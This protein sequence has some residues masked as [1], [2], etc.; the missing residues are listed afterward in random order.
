MAL[1]D[2]LKQSLV[3]SVQI[4]ILPELREKMLNEIKDRLRHLEPELWRLYIGD[5]P[6]AEFPNAAWS[7]T[8]EVVGEYMKVSDSV[9]REISD[10]LMD[11]SQDLWYEVSKE[12]RGKIDFIDKLIK[13]SNEEIEKYFNNCQ[14]VF[15]DT[16]AQLLTDLAFQYNIHSF[17]R[18]AKP[19]LIDYKRMINICGQAIEDIF[20][21]KI[22]CRPQTI[23]EIYRELS[24]YTSRTGSQE[25]ELFFN[26]ISY[27]KIII[28]KHFLERLNRVY[29]LRNKY[30]HGNDTPTDPENDFRDCVRA[31]LEEKYGILH[32]LYDCLAVKP[33]VI[34]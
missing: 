5:D 9:K 14:L 12:I 32:V 19:E 26:R 7:I 13:D 20:C 34:N 22:F 1:R 15:G 25:R 8:E 30:S 31:M 17:T 6:D 11:E 23:G 3:D 28:G 10:T 18:S 16:A 4:N 29:T 27:G 24:A 33:S 21:K 2:I